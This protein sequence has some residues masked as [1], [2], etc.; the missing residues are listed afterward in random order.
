MSAAGSKARPFS[1]PLVRARGV[2][3]RFLQS[4]CNV[5][6]LDEARILVPPSGIE[7]EYPGPRPSALTVELRRMVPGH[8]FEPQF[9]ESES[10][11]LPL[12]EPG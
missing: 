10:G 3:P 12:D 11:V 4:K 8:G 9:P 1:N 7:P 5:L 2:E 6:P